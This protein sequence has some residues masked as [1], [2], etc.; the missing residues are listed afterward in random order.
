MRKTIERYPQFLILA[1]VCLLA[2]VYVRYVFV[3]TK[4]GKKISTSIQK[5]QVSAQKA[6]IQSLTDSLEKRAK[7]LELKVDSLAR[8]KN[9][10]HFEYVTKYREVDSSSNLELA[11]RFDSVFSVNNIK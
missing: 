5:T 8:L 9:K 2:T 4:R 7:S 11:R 1:I 10:I 6:N 3:A